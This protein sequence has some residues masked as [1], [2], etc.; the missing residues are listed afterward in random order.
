M[1]NFLIV[2]LGA[3]GDIVHAIPFAAA[4]RT[5]MPNAQ[6]DWLV[7]PRYRELLDLVPVLTRRIPLSTR[8]LTQS[9][10][11][12]QLYA[13][14]RDLRAT[15]YDVVFDLQGLIK[16]AVLAR[17]ADAEQ[18]V[19]FTKAYLREPLARFL[20]TRRLAPRQPGHVIRQNL[21]LLGAIEVD[22]A[23][24]RFPLDVPASAIADSTRERLGAGPHQAF[25]VINPGAAWPNKQ[26]PPASYGAVAAAL[27][28]SHGLRTLVLW[29]PGEQMLGQAV[30]HAASGAAELAPPT[31]ISDLVAI[32]K[33]AALFISG[34]TGPLHV[35]A[36]VG[37]PLVAL[38]GPTRADRN[39]PI[40]PND[41]VLSRAQVCR[42]LYE[43]RCRLT[44]P[45]I[46]DISVEA[47]VDAAGR[48]LSAEGRQ[49]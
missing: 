10:S 46:H 9:R 6:I 43:R 31:G 41:L 13:S 15:R 34:D 14:L 25:V 7:D 21:S 11:R 42:C 38:F 16:S 48:R 17:A 19:G 40:A 4:L 28:A 3:L 49:A 45:C 12:Q 39:G 22:D 1:R 24:I 47:V 37:T 27:R 44:R 18:T 36:A 8:G 29:G 32:A 5:A 23:R 30:V 20:Y 33:A 35:A 2:R 26:W